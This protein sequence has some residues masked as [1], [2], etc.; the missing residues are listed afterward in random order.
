MTRLFPLV[1]GVLV[2]LHGRLGAQTPAAEAAFSEAIEDNSFFLEE[3]YNQEFRVV[4]HIF[5]GLYYR[6]PLET[7][8]ST[9]TQEWPL[10]GIDNQISYTLAY[11]FLNGPVS[12]GFG[13]VLLNYRYQV[14]PAEAWAAFAPR[15]SVILPT[16]DEDKGLGMGTTGF[17]VDL[18]FSKRFAEHWAV[19]LNLGTT[20]FPG[21]RG[22]DE[23]G[24]EIR[25]SLSW[26]NAG[27]SVI[28]L[29]APTWNIML[30][31]V[32]NASAAIDDAGET[33]RST[34]WIV[35]PGFRYAVNLEGLQIVPGIA[36]PFSVS[37]GSVRTGVFVYLSFEHPY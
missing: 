31:T 9:L 14:L 11:S 35:S 24:A 3:A 16:G 15:F 6:R 18:P 21:V 13:D 34:E 20:L 33:A 7:A 2:L 30:E 25:R 19:H 36:V 10:G 26:Y 27:A 5:N 8:V 1:I 29:A 37:E 4:Q 12:G 28:W 32:M 17:Q 22:T 23:S